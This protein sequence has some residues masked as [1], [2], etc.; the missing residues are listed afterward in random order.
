MASDGYG[1]VIRVCVRVNVQE[2]KV[3]LC[4]VPRSD[5]TV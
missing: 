5:T 4:N 1:G 3:R 2:M